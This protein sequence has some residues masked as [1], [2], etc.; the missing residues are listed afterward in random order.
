MNYQLKQVNYFEFNGKLY[1]TGTKIEFEEEYLNGF[2]PYSLTG[3]VAIF[4]YGHRGR[5][6]IA[7]K[8]VAANIYGEVSNFMVPKRYIKRIIKS[9]PYQEP[10]AIGSAINNW[11]GDKKHPDTFNATLWYLVIMAFLVIVN[12][13]WLYMIIATIVYFMYLIDKYKD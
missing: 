8:D 9:V 1:G 7:C 2:F 4:E 13:G 11:A 5:D 3:N 6:Y 12:N 10:S